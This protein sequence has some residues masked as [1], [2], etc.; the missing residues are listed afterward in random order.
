MPCVLCR[1]VFT[2]EDMAEVGAAVGALNLRPHPIWV[3]Q[4]LD[5]AGDFFIKTGPA[6][7]CL[8]L[9]LGTVQFSS[10]AS[11]DIG[12][13]FPERIVFSGEGH[14]GAFVDYDL[15]FFGREFS[16]LLRSTQNKTPP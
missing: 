6:A 1:E 3:R 11:A 8:K 14:L 9:V 13:F 7:A 5:G 10:A 16:L 4:P 12:A 15:F 2:S